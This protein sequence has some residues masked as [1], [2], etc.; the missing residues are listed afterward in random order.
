MRVSLTAVV[1]GFLIGCAGGAAVD[2]TEQANHTSG[3]SGGSCAAARVLVAGAGV[4][5]APTFRAIPC[6]RASCIGLLQ[7]ERL[8]PV[9][10]AHDWGRPDL[11]DQIRAMTD[12]ANATL[13]PEERDQLIHA[14]YSH[15]DTAAQ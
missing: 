7:K 12:E 13:D 1:S 2:S 14:L 11:V 5:A 3:C 10:L 15:L 6:A 4:A 8:D 9:Q